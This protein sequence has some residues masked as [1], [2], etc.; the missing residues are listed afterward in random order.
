MADPDVESTGTPARRRISPVEVQQQVFRRALFRGYNEQDVDDFLD[1]ITEEISR[2][3]E[4]Q[5]LLREQLQSGAT[6]PVAGVQDVSDATRMAEDIVRQARDQASE[7]TRHAR[8]GA[9]ASSGG[10]GPSLQPFLSQER[11]FLQDL[12]RLIQTHADTVREMARIRRSQPPAQPAASQ[13]APAT[14]A[15]AQ[16]SATAEQPLVVPEEASDSSAVK[17]LFYGE[18]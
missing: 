16:G 2:L 13:P 1:E 3:L 17:E 11:S 8:T 10:G 14:P 6:L 9:A 5:R 12:S 4:D 7:I 18:D 15:A